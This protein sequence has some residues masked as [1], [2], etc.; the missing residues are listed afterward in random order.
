MV[1]EYDLGGGGGGLTGGLFGLGGGFGLDGE[2]CPSPLR[3]K[4]CNLRY[5]L[6]LNIM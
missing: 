1:D 2:T 5:A 4:T 3:R 6:V